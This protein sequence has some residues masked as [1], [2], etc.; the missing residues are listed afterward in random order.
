V[1]KSLSRDYD[2]WKQGIHVTAANRRDYI[3]NWNIMIFVF[4]PSKMR[5]VLADS[6][7]NFHLGLNRNKICLGEYLNYIVSWQ[8]EVSSALLNERSIASKMMQADGVFFDK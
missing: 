5:H 8:A 2:R 1:C 3:I 4:L 7:T 6:T